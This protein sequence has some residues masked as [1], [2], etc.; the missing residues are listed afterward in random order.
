MNALINQKP[1]HLESLLWDNQ[2]DQWEVDPKDVEYTLEASL[3][4][5]SFGIVV[6]G[7]LKRLTTPAAEYLQFPLTG[8]GASNHGTLSERLSA[9]SANLLGSLNKRLK[10]HE[11]TSSVASHGVD[12]AV[13]VIILKHTS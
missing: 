9:M 1:E 3:G 8:K 4:Q 11:N 7:R 13:K 2:N 10:R 6:K 5:G 12:V